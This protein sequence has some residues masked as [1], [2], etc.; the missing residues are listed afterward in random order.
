MMSAI[1]YQRPLAGTTEGDTHQ[2]QDLTEPEQSATEDP[3][4]GGPLQRLASANT[5]PEETAHRITE[6]RMATPIRWPDR[7]LLNKI[8]R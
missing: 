3:A 1:V 4:Q 8:S 6:T 7:D 2:Q 5:Q